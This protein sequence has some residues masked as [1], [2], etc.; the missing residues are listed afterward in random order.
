MKTY[1]KTLFISLIAICLTACSNDDD[2]MKPLQFEKTSYEVCITRTTGIDLSGGSRDLTVTTEN[3][4]I[5]DAAIKM[6]EDGTTQLRIEGKQ[7]GKT[8]VNIKD[9]VTNEIATLTIKVT[10]L[11][12]P[13]RVYRSNHPALVNDLVFYLVK[14]ERHSCYFAR[15]KQDTQKYEIFAQGTYAFQ[16]EPREYSSY[17]TLYYSEDE[18]KFTDATIAPSPHKF[19]ITDNSSTTLLALKSI[20]SNKNDKKNRSTQPIDLNMK[21]VDSNYVIETTLLKNGIIPEGI[22]E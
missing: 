16:L 19:D 9:N 6:N 2:N 5:L 13:F 18:G 20:F 21:G 10:D 7:K 15:P 17:L 12:L 4:E 14:D 22:L 11:Y 1:L 3:P 8:K